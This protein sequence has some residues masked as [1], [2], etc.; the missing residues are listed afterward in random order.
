MKKKTLTYIDY[1]LLCILMLSCKNP[2]STDTQEPDLAAIS[3]TTE[4]YFEGF[5]CYSPLS[6]SFEESISGKVFPVDMQGLSFMIETEYPEIGGKINVPVFVKLTGHLIPQP[7]AEDK[8]N[9]RLAISSIKEVCEY[10][11]LID[12]IVGV[13]AGSGQE[14]MLI[15]DHSYTLKDKHGNISEGKWYL[16]SSNMMVLISGDSK[17]MMKINYKK[18]CL[19]SREDL[20]VVFTFISSDLTSR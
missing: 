9:V 6:A 17:T 20:P 1:L 4:Q 5:F 3:E 11:L 8:S 16:Y 12:P 2:A 14:L 15:P 10:G 18:K 7:D 19:N 13:Y